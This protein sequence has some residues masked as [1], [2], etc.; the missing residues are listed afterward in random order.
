[1]SFEEV[2]VIKKYPNPDTPYGW[3]WYKKKGSE[4]YSIAKVTAKSENYPAHIEG[5]QGSQDVKLLDGE[6][7]SEIIFNIDNVHKEKEEITTTPEGRFIQRVIIKS[8]PN[9]P[10]GGGWYWFKEK[11]SHQFIPVFVDSSTETWPSVVRIGREY[12]KTSE[13]E[14]TWGEYIKFYEDKG[15]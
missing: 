5:Y 14:G 3:Y 13:I 7:G 12:P 8:Y 9:P 10:E 6:W 1:M 11:R 2:K 4:K 15:E